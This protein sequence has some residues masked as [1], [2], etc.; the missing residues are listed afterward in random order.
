LA[1]TAD[2]KDVEPELNRVLLLNLRGKLSMVLVWPDDE[3]RASVLD[4]GVV[5]NVRLNA[6]VKANRTIVANGGRKSSLTLQ[7]CLNFFQQNEKLDRN[8]TWYCNVCKDHKE[9]WKM[10]QI[11]SLP[12]VLVVQL[13]RF[14]NQGGY[15]NKISLPVTFPI[16]GLDMSQ[17]VLSARQGG[18]VYDLFAV[19]N[20]LGDLGGGHYTAYAKHNVTH[21][22]YLFDDS[23]VALVENEASI[24]SSAAYILFYVRRE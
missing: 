3:R 21:K 24:I 7:D 4:V 13:K 23:R 18:W 17:Y 20:H 19:V 15:R 22:W 5:L 2:E 8:N 11:H 9:A 14:R 16:S 1:E 10:M 12:T 6:S